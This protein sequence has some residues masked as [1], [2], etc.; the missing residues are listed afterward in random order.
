MRDLEKAL[1]ELRGSVNRMGAGPAKAA[2][3][4]AS[5]DVIDALLV[6][7]PHLHLNLPAIDDSRP[8]DV[9]TLQIELTDRRVEERP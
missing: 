7:L 6:A 5:E 2:I 4:E 9:Q 8:P 3:R 1:A